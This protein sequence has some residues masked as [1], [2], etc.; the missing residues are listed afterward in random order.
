MVASIRVD[1]SNIG[2][3]SDLV[4]RPPCS[5]SSE[6]DRVGVVVAPG[7]SASGI[8]DGEVL[9]YGG[10]GRRRNDRRGPRPR[11]AVHTDTSP[12]AAHARMREDADRAGIRRIHVFAFR[13]R[14][15]PEAGGSEEHAHQVC[16]HLALAG[17]EVTLHTGRVP[18]GPRELRRD[19]YRVVRRGGR[20]GVFAASVLDEWRGRLGPADGLVEIFHGVPFFAPLWSRRPQVGM[21]HHVH[22]GTWGML[23]PGLP[24]RAGEAVERHLV[25]R[26]YRRRALVTAAESA[27]DEMVERYG[28]APD[29]IA[30]APHGIDPRFS[31]GG[32]RNPAPLVVAVARLM[33]QKG[34]DDLLRALVDVQRQVPGLEAVIIGDGPHRAALEATAR[35]LHLEGAVTFAGRVDDAALLDWYRRAWVVASASKAEGFGLTLTEAAACGTPVVATRIPGHVDAVDE[36][37]G[38]LLAGTTAELGQLLTKVLLDGDLPRRAGSRRPRARRALPVGRVRRAAAARPRRRGH[39]AAMSR[40]RP[41]ALAAAADLVVLG[42]ITLL[43]QLL[44][45]RGRLNADTKQYLYLDPGSLLERSRHVW[46]RQVGGGTVTH[47]AIGYLWPTGPYYWATDA[48]GI[49]D[50]AAQRLWVGGI[51]LVAA[52]GALA[53]LRHLLPRHPVLLVPAAL[54]GLSPV[55]LGHVTGQSALLLPFAALPWLV[56]V[57]ARAVEEGGWRWPAVFALIVGSCGSLNGS[58]VFFVLLAPVLWVPFAVGSL[59]AATPRAGMAALGRAGA[60]TLAC[61]LWWLGAYAVG[62]ASNL[63]ILALTENVQTTSYTASAAEILRGL[64]YWFFYGGDS[65][66]PW[67]S[68]IAIPYVRSLPLVV[69]TFALPIAALALGAAVRWPPRAYFALLVGVGTVIAAGAFPEPARSPLGAAFEAA[70]RRSDLVLSLRNTQRATPLVVLGLAGLA[71]AGLTALRRRHRGAGAGAALVLAVLVVAALP[72]QWRSG[73]I[74][75]RFHR[76]EL[77]DEWRAAMAHLDEGSGRILELP[78]IDFASFR[79]GHTLDP[80]SVGLTDRPVLAR[81]LVPMGGLPGA[82]LLGALDRSFQEGWAEPAALAPVARLLGATDVLARND[83]EY[84]RYRTVRPALFWATVSDPAAGLGTPA[85]FGPRLPNRAGPA[86]P[87]ID[88]IELG[89][90]ADAPVPPEVAVLPVPGGGRAALS[91]LPVEGALVVDGDGE[92]LVHAAAAGVLDGVDGAVLLA[93][94]LVRAGGRLDELLSDSSRL[95]LTDSNRK[96][97]FRWYSLRENA[98]ATEPLDHRAAIDDPS[99]TRTPLVE[100]QP[101]DA[102]T[103]VDWRGAERV[104]ASRYGSGFTLLA[105]ERPV[106][107]FDGDRSTAWRV[108]HVRAAGAARDRH[109]ARPAQRRRPRRPRAAPGPARFPAGHPGADHPRRRAQRRRLAHTGTGPSP[110]GGSGGARRAALRDA[111]GADPGGRPRRRP[112]RV[113]GGVHPGHHRRGGGGAPHRAHGRARRARRRDAHEHRADPPPGRPRRAGAGG[114]GDGPASGLAAA[115]RARA[116]ALRHGAPLAPRRRRHPRRAAGDSVPGTRQRTAP[117]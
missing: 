75:D 61:Q 100:G 12:T 70:S 40:L 33:P 114:S 99:D 44:G 98:G 41:R 2:I 57:M 31:P 8:P 17:R 58:S 101:P 32:A 10:P 5:R 42:S 74:A 49:P 78:G 84:E 108:E 72:G 56:L 115:R 85:M 111:G 68:S 36:G 50:W 20:Y 16:R 37:A 30:L 96:R 110:G 26:V 38:G 9:E 28:I 46:D 109:R 105:E 7:S 91:T 64:G 77:P 92:G 79:W 104:W 117:G 24:G 53:L 67:L 93:A 15:D 52:L 82:S 19:G 21:V 89:L 102:Q 6:G 94:D 59:R 103:T 51:Q 107:A 116:R 62:G 106:L 14:D 63:P 81:E 43:P 11:A 97:A 55:V 13:D 112:G 83:L 87:M 29:R 66:G 80:V 47:Q 69:V 25:P 18:G 86:R 71:A 45:G 35:A 113:R 54:Y 88:E 76:E 65:E 34:V 48:L 73:L 39:P 60:L 22:L 27:R 95:L 1:S 4:G 3:T 90:D 23:L